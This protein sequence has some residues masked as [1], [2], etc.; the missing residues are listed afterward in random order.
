MNLEIWMLILTSSAFQLSVPKAEF[1]TSYLPYLVSNVVMS[2]LSFGLLCR[3]ARNHCSAAIVWAAGGNMARTPRSRRESRPLLLLLQY[4]PI[5]PR[6]AFQ[7]Q[8][9][10][11][12]PLVCWSHITIYNISSVA[13]GPIVE[14]TAFLVHRA[15]AYFKFSS[16]IRCSM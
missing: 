14:S 3:R 1:F 2:Y 8:Y 9:V 6:Y 11:V 12:E 7:F 5:F 4:L 15:Y 10:S 16:T 13:S